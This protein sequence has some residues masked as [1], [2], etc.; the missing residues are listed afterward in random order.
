MLQLITEFP[1]WAWALCLLAG[2]SYAFFFYWWQSA[3]N[4]P[5]Y[6]FRWLLFA[7]R[8]I[9]VTIIAV[10]LLEPFF[11]IRSNEEVLPVAVV[12]QDN[13][14]SVAMK[15][16]D[17]AAY[18]L[19]MEQF[20][21]RLSAK[22]DVQ[23]FTFGDAWESDKAIDFSE[24]ATNMEAAL[25][26]TAQLYRYA[27][28]GAV[29]LAGD[30]I[31]NTGADP[32]GFTTDWPAPVYSIA[33]GDTTPQKDLRVVRALSN[34]IVFTG[35]KFTI[36]T[37]IA[38]TLL[39]N[40]T[41]VAAIERADGNGKALQTVNIA[42]TDNAFTATHDFTLTAERPGLHRYRVTLR[43]DAT[44][45][46]TAN[47]S[48]EVVVEVLDARQKVLLLAKAPHPDI[49]ALRAALEA[50]RNYDLTVS[51]LEGYT[52]DAADYSLVILHNLPGIS[53][54]DRSLQED[55]RKA[56]TPV[57]FITG[58]TVNTSAFHNMQTLVRIDGGGK[59]GNEVTAS[60]NKGFSLF[61][62]EEDAMG[63]I[64]RF[65]PLLAPYGEYKVSNAAQTLF[66]QKIGSVSTAMPLMVY[67]QPGNRKMAVTCGENIW[68]WRLYDYL[69]NT[70]HDVFNSWIS[71]TVQ[72]LASKD[73][74]KQFRVQTANAVYNTSEQVML[75]A[76][77][78]NEIY[79]RINTPEATC[80]ITDGEGN[81]Y[82]YT[83]TRTGNRYTLNA[84]LLP[85]GDYQVNAMVTYNNKQ[86]TDQTAFSIVAIDLETSQTVANHNLLYRLASAA[87]GSMYYPDQLDSM[88]TALLNS[89]YATPVL[90]E[91]IRTRSVLNLGWILF[92]IV[93]LLAIE[94]F[95]RKWSG[96]Y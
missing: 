26:G 49:A 1:W 44:E 4:A 60:G 76:E 93:G 50:N 73:D 35:D 65:P 54:N 43:S 83:F 18:R 10:L 90:E 33:L 24:G 56:A 91:R 15:L 58:Q 2:G 38:A 30:G 74:S 13:S 92:C 51:L 17:T 9:G 32:E 69:D 45:A 47:N 22:Y 53:A 72:Y 37:D 61:I 14:A 67:S 78:Y 8:C 80:T 27:R 12:L 23:A 82:P 46:N 85:E 59:S 62:M 40:T 84:G 21:E 96:G 3:E 19:S 88:A 94:W 95:L 25:N 55:L 34:N 48:Y 87:G 89:P 68:R 28:L 39:Q 16:Q 75:E 6:S 66:F 81:A 71:K 86:L 11:R 63:K 77:L 70:S 41:A 7:L 42:V 36:R 64:G 5:W 20:K 57:W 31:F 29:I 52:G 79:E